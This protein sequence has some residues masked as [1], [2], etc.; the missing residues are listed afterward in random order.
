[1]PSR[2]LKP[3][4][5]LLAC[6]LALAAAPSRAE[7]A[8]I[9]AQQR[10]LN[11][12]KAGE[13]DAAIAAG[14]KLAR[15]FP[16]EPRGR[17]AHFHIANYLE[18]LATLE[19]VTLDDVRKTLES[20][21]A[22]YELAAKTPGQAK[23]ALVKSAEGAARMEQELRELGAIARGET[24]YVE[25]SERLGD[26]EASR[27]AAAYLRAL[28]DSGAAPRDHLFFLL[29]V[30]QSYHT[31]AMAGRLRE[32]YDAL[33]EREPDL[34]ERAYQKYQPAMEAAAR[35]Q[36]A[37]AERALEEHPRASYALDYRVYLGF[38]FQYSASA[39]LAERDWLLAKK[40]KLAGT[41]RSEKEKDKENEKTQQL[42]QAAARAALEAAS[43][44]AKARQTNLDLLKIV[45]GR[46]ALAAPELAFAAAPSSAAVDLLRHHKAAAERLEALAAP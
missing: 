4:G 39:K 25:A 7:D 45:E 32:V 38:G 16:A 20:A 44:L 28:L 30:H 5:L 9:A 40:E 35:E 11:L 8:S 21:K 6:A 14:E 43:F 33:R 29:L 13:F 3:F 15:D 41:N 37:T 12:W 46:L 1:M 31:D 17:T 26:S 42:S 19:C 34:F 24:G 2:F 22:H 10:A 18:N 27:A 23:A 36:I